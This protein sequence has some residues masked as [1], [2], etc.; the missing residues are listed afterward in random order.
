MAPYEIYP[1]RLSGKGASR[2]CDF[3]CGAMIW[4]GGGVLLSRREPCRI[5]HLFGGLG[6]FVETQTTSGTVGAAVKI[7]GSN[8]TGA[9]SVPF[10]GTAA[11]FAVAAASEIK[12][13]APTGAKRSGSRLCGRLFL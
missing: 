7:L 1:P 12:A 8:L 11:T 9:R 5:S 2:Q 3:C 4:A 13:T 10:N 6:A